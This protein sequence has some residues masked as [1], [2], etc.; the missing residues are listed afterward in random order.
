MALT[1]VLLNPRRFL[2]DNGQS[3]GGD[4]GVGC[5]AA[6][7]GI[8]EKRRHFWKKERLSKDSGLNPEGE[9]LREQSNYPDVAD[10]CLPAYLCGGFSAERS[11]KSTLSAWSP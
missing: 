10:G 8:R 5:G 1:K 7:G 4:I 9:S 11:S 6:V 3:S 2:G